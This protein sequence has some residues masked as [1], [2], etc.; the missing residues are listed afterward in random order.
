[1]CA[2]AL[3]GGPERS[4]TVH[5]AAGSQ[6]QH[7]CRPDPEP[8]LRMWP[9]PLTTAGRPLPTPVRATS[10]TSPPGPLRRV[11]GVPG[12]MGR[13]LRTRRYQWQVPK[14]P[15]PRTCNSPLTQAYPYGWRP[16][17]GQPTNNNVQALRAPKLHESATWTM[18][19]LVPGC[20]QESGDSHGQGQK[21]VV[22]C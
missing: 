4:T 11:L 7:G 9:R 1:M 14:P 2:H 16:R 12:G 22:G 17:T 8:W 3:H 13:A 5:R 20:R 18:S 15:V 10:P 6:P 19:A 21:P